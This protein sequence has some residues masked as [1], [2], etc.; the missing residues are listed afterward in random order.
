MQTHRRPFRADIYLL[1][2]WLPS[3][4][5]TGILIMKKTI[6][7]FFLLIGYAETSSAQLFG[8]RNYE[9][10]IIEGMQGV[11][12]D[13]AAQA[14]ASACL[15]KFSKRSRSAAEHIGWTVQRDGIGRCHMIWDGAEFIQTKTR[16]APEAFSHYELDLP[17]QY[18]LSLYIPDAISIIDD[19]SDEQG[20]LRQ[21]VGM[22]G[23]WPGMFC[24]K[25]S[26]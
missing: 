21:I 15:I 8:P 14:V 12:S 19:P 24:G 4:I 13:R 26:R 23:Q 1:A 16:K 6:L 25:P 11:T 17:R 22:F 7:L 10:C 20:M 2:Y 18:K 5:R 3:R 9:D